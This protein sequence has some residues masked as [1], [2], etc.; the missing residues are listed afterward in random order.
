[1]SQWKVKDGDDRQYSKEDKHDEDLQVVIDEELIVWNLP[2]FIQILVENVWV[3][4]VYIY[5]VI[6]NEIIS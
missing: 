3:D 4:I 5:P 6:F 1:M 2:N